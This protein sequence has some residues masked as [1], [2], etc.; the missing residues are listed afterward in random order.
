MSADQDKIHQRT[1]SLAHVEQMA[2]VGTRVQRKKESSRQKKERQAKNPGVE[3]TL[4]EE[5]DQLQNKSS[6]SEGHI[7]FHA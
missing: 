7:D 6:E 1:D 5:Q 3:E 4:R 2:A